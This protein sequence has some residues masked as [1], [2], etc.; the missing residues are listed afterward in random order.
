MNLFPCAIPFCQVYHSKKK[1][2]SVLLRM[3]FNQDIILPFTS[4][5]R[6]ELQLGQVCYWHNHRTQ[7]SGLLPLGYLS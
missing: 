2:P 6:Q 1:M 3:A 4:L 5:R 7:S